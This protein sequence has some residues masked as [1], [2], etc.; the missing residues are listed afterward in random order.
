[1]RL[2]GL[3]GGISTGKTTVSNHLSKNYQ[4]P[5]WDADIYAREAVQPGS[6][7]LESIVEHY[8]KNIVLPNGNLNRQKLGEIVFNDK[9]ELHWL[10]Q[11]IHPYVRHRFQQNIQHFV[12]KNSES[13]QK[14]SIQATSHQTT[15]QDPTAVLVI[16][17][18]FE[19][20]MTDLVTEI[21]VIYSTPQQQ[22]ERLMKRDCLTQQQ[23]YA[24]INNQMS[25]EEKCQKADLVVD[26]SSTLEVL[27]KQVDSAIAYP[28]NNSVYGQKHHLKS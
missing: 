13:E 5:I 12:V 6:S 2:I 26:N 16:P 20:K 24:R 27:L 21:W 18:L 1:M 7:I 25:L 9:N 3:T 10:E 23:A 8:G 28:Q 15:A 22:I 17:L 4:F 19:A 11:Q 14:N